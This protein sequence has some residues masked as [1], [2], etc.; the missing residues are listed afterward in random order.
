MKLLLLGPPGGGK[1]TQSKFLVNKFSIPQISTGDMLREHLKN[2]TS[3]GQK[4]QRFMDSGNLVPDDIILN[5]MENRFKKTDCKKGYILDGFPRT[6]TQ[7][8]GLEKLLSHLKQNLDLVIVINVDD[9]IIIDRMGGRRIHPASG[10][11]YHIK[12]NPPKKNDI[13]DITGEKLIIRIDDQEDTVKK[14]LEVYHSLTKPLINFYQSKDI[15][16]FINGEN[17][18]KKVR[19][20]IFHL[21]DTKKN[22]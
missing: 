22:V 21:I 6:L 3:L 7:A 5:M 8:E 12:F 19:R 18:I 1:G 20:D 16:S 14:R 13:D 2:N 15:I 9:D 17:E 4:A 11:T 10:R